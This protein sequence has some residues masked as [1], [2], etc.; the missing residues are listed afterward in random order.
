MK[1]IFGSFS[2]SK[3]SWTGLVITNAYLEIYRSIMWVNASAG[4]ETLDFGK[5]S[6]DDERPSCET[7]VGSTNKINILKSIYDS[8]SWRYY[9]C[10]VNLWL[11]LPCIS[12]SLFIFNSFFNRWTIFLLSSIQRIYCLLRLRKLN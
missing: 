8:V 2:L 9:I 3:P 1:I 7:V 6:S 11:W 12:C 10:I 4:A 5:W